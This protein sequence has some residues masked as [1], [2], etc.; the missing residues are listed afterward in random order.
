MF[1]ERMEQ[2]E[3]AE[4]YDTHN[5]FVARIAC[6]ILGNERDALDVTDQAMWYAFCH[7]D[8]FRGMPICAVRSYLAGMARARS[9]DMIRHAR[10]SDYTDITSI[11]DTLYDASDENVEWAVEMND[12]K[13]TV[14]R[15]LRS[16]SDVYRDTF[17]LRI[18]KGMTFKEVAI[19]LGVPIDTVKS[20]WR[21]GLVMI[22][23]VVRSRGYG[24][25]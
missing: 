1:S 3:F 17:V 12:L 5:G 11:L 4:F 6:C 10:R 23:R 7:P 16:M 18:A 20:R 2:E 14:E 22:E 8:K 19:E 21:R 15:C 9:F 25:L 24:S 13:D